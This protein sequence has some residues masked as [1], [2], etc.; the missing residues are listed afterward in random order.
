MMLFEDLEGVKVEKR[1]FYAARLSKHIHTDMTVSKK[2]VSLTSIHKAP[3]KADQ[4]AR[5]LGLMNHVTGLE[6]L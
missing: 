2:L 6:N 1:P 5:S 3:V 4:S